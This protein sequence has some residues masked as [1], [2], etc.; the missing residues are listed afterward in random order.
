MPSSMRARSSI[1]SVPS[2]RSRTSASSAS[3][4]ALRPA[5]VA[6][7]WARLWS[8]SHTARQLPLPS[9]SGYCSATRSVARM[10]A[11]I[12][13]A[14]YPLLGPPPRGR[15]QFCPGRPERGGR[16]S[17]DLVKS[18]AAGV[19]GVLAQLLLDPQELVV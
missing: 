19:G 6:R 1:A 5:L 11:R 10:A 9:H 18:I 17:A 13:T 16:L 12:F 2:L 8:S 7:C 4:R 3:L 15:E 14:V